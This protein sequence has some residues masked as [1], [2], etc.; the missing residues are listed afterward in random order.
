MK[1]ISINLFEYSELEEPAKV[2]ALNAFYYI[3][4]FD[5]WHETVYSDFINI[6]QSIGLYVDEKQIYFS[7][8]FSQGDG[9]AF[10]ANVDV[11]ELINGITNHSYKTVAPSLELSLNMPKINCHVI[12]LL[13]NRAIDCSAGIKPSSKG[14][15]VYADFTLYATSLHFHEN[16]YAE[17]E[18]LNTWFQEIAESLNAYLFKS[19]QKDYEYQTSESAIIE[20]IEANDYHFT[21]DGKIAT[22]IEKLA[23]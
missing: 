21:L 20:A 17:I 22:H 1:T 14:N 8:F 7:G 15:S 12:K 10:K 11:A 6:V 19:L 5:G 16:I 3:N 13:K 9:S 4:I 23:N 2:N 18:K